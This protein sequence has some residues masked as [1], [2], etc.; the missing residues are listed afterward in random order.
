MLCPFC[1]T[2]NAYQI[3][4]KSGNVIIIKWTCS[5]C[6]KNWDNENERET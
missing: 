3:R 4:M 1:N 5:F 6:F 2:K